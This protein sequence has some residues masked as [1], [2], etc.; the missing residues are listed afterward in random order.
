MRIQE[1]ENLHLPKD[2]PITRGQIHRLLNA[3]GIA[4]RPGATREELV[5]ICEDEGLSIYEAAKPQI[6][7]AKPEEVNSEDL[8]YKK[9]RAPQMRKIANQKGANFPQTAKKVEMMEWLEANG[10]IA[11]RH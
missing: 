2:R 4:H 8:D 1:D 3:K 6:P 10:H 5:R 9:M 7:K 11:Q